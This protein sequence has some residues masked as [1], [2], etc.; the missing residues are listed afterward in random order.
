MS[1]KCPCS[2]GKIYQKCCELYI[3]GVKLPALPEELMRSRYSA[4]TMA[5][6]DYIV[7]TMYGKALQGFIQK[8]AYNWAKSVI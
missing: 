7:K 5:N 8:D 4:Y 1:K 3:S 2:S 6:I